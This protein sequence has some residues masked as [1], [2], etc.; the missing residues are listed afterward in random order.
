MSWFEKK[1]LARRR[2][3]IFLDYAS[4]TPV[5]PEV[6]RV[7]EKYWSRDFYNPSAIY[8]EGVRIKE[9]IEQS[10]AG[11]A[12]SLGVA[13]PGIIFTASGT[14]SDNLAVL[15]A[16]EAFRQR[17]AVAGQ[18][19]GKK[20]KDGKPHIIISAIEHPAVVGAAEEVV[21]RGGEMSVLGVDE[22]GR[23]SPEALKK[24]LKKNTF[25]VS[26]GLANNE[27]GTIQP[28][29]KIGR[30]LREYRKSHSSSYPY[31]HTDAS[32]APSFLDV[33][34]ETLH[35][36][37][38]TLDNSKIYGPKGVGVL[39]VRRGVK[40]CPII[41]GG[42]Q[43]GNRRS[44]TLNPALVSG[45]A[46]ALKIALRDREKESRRLENLREYFI[47]SVSGYLPRVVVNGS[48]N[49]H[50]P[51]IVNVSL[52][53]VLSEFIL[54]KLDKAGVMVSVGSACSADER[55]S[56]SPVIRALGKSELA[57]STL[58]FSFGRF[59]TAGEVKQAVKIFC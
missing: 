23:V 31:L 16:F 4:A 54:L 33:S 55:V 43:E 6:R 57:E 19:Q 36:D 5:L 32:Q 41:F 52:P 50:L 58:R 21:R 24:L 37:L 46:L 29:S 18:A 53:G 25:L 35:L 59:T 47:E 15:G 17:S 13:P 28:L 8:Q 38:L 10:R 40:I 22:E 45:F 11:V 2:G 48:R 26:I 39:A 1:S 12:L 27:I 42:G 56:G 20:A 3:R 34:L 9:E 14:E 30:L 49:N 51:N 44:G 7:M